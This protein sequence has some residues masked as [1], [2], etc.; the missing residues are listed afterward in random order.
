MKVAET[1]PLGLGRPLAGRMELGELA[2]LAGLYFVLAL[3]SIG[4]ALQPGAIADVWFPNVVAIAV[5]AGAPRSRWAALLLAVAG[6]NFAANVA[7]RGA[8]LL[9]ASFVPGNLAEIV[10]GAWLLQRFDLA[11]S[12]DEGGGEFLADRKSVV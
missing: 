10:L 7:L 4:L 9:S 3:I 1:L 11:R 8:P 12:F 5:L 2:L 6:A